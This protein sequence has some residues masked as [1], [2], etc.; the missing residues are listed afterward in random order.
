MVGNVLFNCL[1]PILGFHVLSRT[2]HTDIL[3]SFWLRLTGIMHSSRHLN[4]QELYLEYAFFRSFMPNITF[5]D[6]FRNKPGAM[7]TRIPMFTSAYREGYNKRGM[8]YVHLDKSLE[9]LIVRLVKGLNVTM[10]PFRESSGAWLLAV[11]RARMIL[12]SVTAATRSYRQERTNEHIEQ[13]GEEIHG[14][15]RNNARVT[16]VNSMVQ[17]MRPKGFLALYHRSREKLANVLSSSV[18]E[19]SDEKVQS[20]ILE[21]DKLGRKSTERHASAMFPEVFGHLSDEDYKTYFNGQRLVE[22][23]QGNAIFYGGNRDRD[24]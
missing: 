20:K 2:G 24:Q 14:Y 5:N 15:D 19:Q 22:N 18:Q 21:I 23:G 12:R 4:Y 10:L 3:D 9:M 6:L 17:I 8:N 11:S 13:Q 1:L 16:T 7:V